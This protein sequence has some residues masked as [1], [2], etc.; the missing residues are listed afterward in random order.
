MHRVPILMYH[1]ITERLNAF[2]H[3]FTTRPHEFDA[4]MSRLGELGYRS[5]TMGALAA[6]W[7]AGKPA[8]ARS[9]VITFDDAF[10]CVLDAAL[11]I[12]Q[13]HGHTATVYAIAGFLGRDNDYDAGVG[14]SRRR[15]VSAD[16]LRELH[17]AGIEIGSHTVG[18]PRLRRLHGDALRHEIVD[19]KSMLEDL[20][21]VPVP[22]FAYPYGGFSREARDWVVRA[23]YRSAVSTI[24]GLAGAGDDRFLLRRATVGAG[25]DTARFDRCLRHGGDPREIARAAARRFVRTQLGRLRGVDPV[26]SMLASLKGG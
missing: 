7:S 17:A 10:D 11:P 26:D 21:G 18:H 15:I 16:Q 19:S 3:G 5:L 9:V 14:A 1:G 13:R 4:Q 25:F 2:E 23:G 12:L 8:P 22:S 20:L 24:D 6:L